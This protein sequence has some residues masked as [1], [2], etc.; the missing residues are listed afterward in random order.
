MEKRGKNGNNKINFEDLTLKNL[1]F[2]L[3]TTH[4]A[5]AK[6]SSEFWSSMANSRHICSLFNVEVLK[7][8]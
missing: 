8:H 4:C 7:S 1:N 6:Y 5:Q 2:E 3:Q